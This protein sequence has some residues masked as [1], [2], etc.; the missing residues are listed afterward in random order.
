M[1]QPWWKRE[2][3]MNALLRLTNGRLSNVLKVYDV[4]GA[5]LN[6]PPTY[7]ELVEFLEFCQDD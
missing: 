5:E 4:L 6:R 1:S 3:K 2:Q 7:D